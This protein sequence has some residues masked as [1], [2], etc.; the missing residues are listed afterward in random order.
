VAQIFRW[1][2]IDFSGEVGYAYGTFAGYPQNGM[3]KLLC[4]GQHLLLKK[5]A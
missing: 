1:G 3:G 5:F 2:G 4:N